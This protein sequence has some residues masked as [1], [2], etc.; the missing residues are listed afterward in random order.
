[1]PF[2]GNCRLRRPRPGSTSGNPASVGV[3]HLEPA[4]LPNHWR[5]DVKPN[6][7]DEDPAGDEPRPVWYATADRLLAQVGEPDLTGRPEQV[8]DMARFMLRLVVDHYARNLHDAG[9]RE[10]A[11][12]HPYALAAFDVQDAEARA[13]VE[14]HVQERLGLIRP[15]D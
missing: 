15:E 14:Q 13:I 10:D 5:A 8:A 3:G 9:Q 11:R 12:V 6:R 7:T 1:M 2:R 4:A